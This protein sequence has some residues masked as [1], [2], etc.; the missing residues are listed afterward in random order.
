M[1]NSTLYIPRDSSAVSLGADAVA[2]RIRTQAAARKLD[3]K[4]VRNGSRGMFS[5]EPM[6]EVLTTDGRIAYGPV[7][8]RDVASLFDANFLD[9]REHRLRLGVADE[10]PWLKSQTRLTFARA[11]LIDPVSLDDFVAHGG[12]RGLGRAIEIGSD[13]VI[14]EVTQ[15]GLRGRGGGGVSPCLQGET[16][17]D[18]PPNHELLCS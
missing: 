10:I 12:Y 3:V 7:R 18:A 2:E 11:G 6:V 5:H 16:G 4:I 8:A 1:T 14:A 15:S 9:G 13:A 17:G